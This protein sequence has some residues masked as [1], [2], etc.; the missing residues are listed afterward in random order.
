M[1]KTLISHVF[2]RFSTDSL[3]GETV[4]WYRCLIR[5]YRFCPCFAPRS[6]LARKF[7]QG[8]GNCGKLMFVQG[9][10]QSRKPW[11]QEPILASGPYNS[12]GTVRGKNDV[13]GKSQNPKAADHPPSHI[14]FPPAKPVAGGSGELM[15][16]VMPAFPITDQCDP[17]A[18][19]GP[20]PDVVG[21]VAKR[22]GST[23]DEPG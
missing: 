23:V 1:K 20:V 18:I 21:P 6:R 12:A 8:N 13:L 10:V 4:Y 9:G 17:P 16:V 14:H 11:P 22:M 19:R 3:R 7:H 5:T 15:M 2:F